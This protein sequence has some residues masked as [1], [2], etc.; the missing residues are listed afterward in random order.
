M[1]ATILHTEASIGFGGQEVRILAEARWL[2]DHGW[3]ALIAAQ[4]GGRLLAEA[5]AAGLPAAA[6]PMRQPAGVGAVLR[7]RRLMGERGVDL[8]HTHSSVDSWVATLAA[9]SRRLPVVR[10]RHV[11]IPIRRRR[12]LIYRLA[13]RVIASGTAVKAT[14]EAAG[15]P[16]ARVRSIPAGIDTRRFHAGVSG[17]RVRAEF[18][19]S[20]P[21]IGLV[22]NI[23]GSK[24]H[25]HLL[26]AVPRVLAERPRARFLI[27]GDGVGFDD[28][29]RSVADRGLGDRVVMTGFRRDVPEVMAALDVLVLPSVRSE[30]TSQVVPQ[31]LAVG[32]P[33]VGTAVGGIPE[34]VRDGETGRLVPPG[35]AA[36]L[37]EAILDLLGDPER[38]RAMARRGQALVMS[39]FTF[40]A[41][42]EAT[43]AVYAEL[44]GR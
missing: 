7:L 13:D 23:R 30:A 29:R 10:S 11:S 39:R 37:A 20:G 34:I 32:T 19:N 42:M 14:I 6:V 4:P 43:A 27:V 17:A 36:A 5:A 18:G 38:A 16:A 44:L 22:A 8:V 2:L 9:K 25:Q 41:M 12:A 26:Q 31:A 28:V 3:D 15:V 1:K 40:E 33:V 35:D 24:G 21:L